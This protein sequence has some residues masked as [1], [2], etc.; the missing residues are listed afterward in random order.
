MAQWRETDP[1]TDSELP[2]SW[3]C[4]QGQ[5][6]TS[7]SLSVW[8]G[9]WGPWKTKDTICL[10]PSPSGRARGT[11]FP[12]ESSR[13]DWTTNGGALGLFSVYWCAL[14]I[15]AGK[16]AQIYITSNYINNWTRTIMPITEW[17]ISDDLLCEE[18][19]CAHKHERIKA[20]PITTFIYANKWRCSNSWEVHLCPQSSGRSILAG[21][22]FFSFLFRE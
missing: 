15:R 10:K 20:S 13:G 12:A 3:L 19:N 11:C 4:E 17:P 9:K 5:G 1:S 14:L 21:V 16:I 6:S 2:T 18:V 22:P 7:V 8:S